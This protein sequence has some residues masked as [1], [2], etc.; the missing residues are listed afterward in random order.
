M[1]QVINLLQF[2]KNI[3]RIKQELLTQIKEAG[4]LLY[5]YIT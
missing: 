2:R 4:I 3:F 5:M 1:F